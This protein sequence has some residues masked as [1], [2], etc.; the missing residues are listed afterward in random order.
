MKRRLAFFL[1]FVAILS[2]ILVGCAKTEESADTG[3][4]GEEAKAEQ[5]ELMIS[6]AASLTNVSKE[7]AV[8]YAETAPNVKLTFTFGSSGALQTQIEEGAPA[9]VFFSAALKQMKALEDGGYILEGTK[10]EL[11]INEVMLIAPKGNPAKVEGFEDAATDKVK[12]IALGDPASVPVGQ[13]SEEVF[14]HLGILDQV[15]PKAN[16]GTDVVQVLTWVES[17]EV[18]CGVV[19]ATDAAASDK[20]DVICS[21]PEGSH[22]TVTYPVAVIKSSKN[23]DEAKKFVD[24]LSSDQAKAKFE[25]YG[26]TINE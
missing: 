3:W 17:G 14:T 25:S 10:K 1:I 18:D 9:D 5:V 26:F 8:L 15:T 11:L 16:Y 23:A 7:L 4:G 22:K 6:A 2:I 19:Y 21:A 13:Y 24:F 12:T 20:I